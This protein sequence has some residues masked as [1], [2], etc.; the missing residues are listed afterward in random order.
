MGR[1]IIL[2]L[3]LL[4]YYI[5]ISQDTE[6]DEM[7]DEIDTDSV[8]ETKPYNWLN[9]ASIDLISGGILRS[10]ARL[11]NMNIGEPG[12]FY[13][14]FYI[15]VEARTDIGQESID[16]NDV[17]MADMLLNDGGYINLGFIGNIPIQKKRQKT[18][19]SV[20]Y[21]VGAKSVTGYLHEEDYGVSFM[22]YLM[23][24]G[25]QYNTQT[26]LPSNRDVKGEAFFKV[27]FSSSINDSDKMQLLFGADVQPLV[28]GL[29]FETGM[30]FQSSFHLKFSYH[31]YLNNQSIDLFQNEIY[32]I[33]LQ[34][35]K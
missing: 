12:K 14:P 25:L 32:C 5:L 33:S 34:M 17:T 2:S 28:H 13:L 24:L 27:Y 19:L 3:C 7:I 30:D 20:P 9:N 15:M 22:S 21:Q 16:F 10:G 26:W 18:G 8:I 1:I 29:S 35:Q 23:S 11:F 6:E 4:P 31:K